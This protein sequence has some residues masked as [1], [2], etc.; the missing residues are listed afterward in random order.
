M[1]VHENKTN[2]EQKFKATMA[3][4]MEAA[5][6]RMMLKIMIGHKKQNLEH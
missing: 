6:W 3:K 4:V 2:C 5:T 1:I